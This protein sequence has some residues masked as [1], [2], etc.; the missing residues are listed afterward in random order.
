M[1]FVDFISITV[2][3]VLTAMAAYRLGRRLWRRVTEPEPNT[4]NWR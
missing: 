3:V 1:M 4:H 2:L